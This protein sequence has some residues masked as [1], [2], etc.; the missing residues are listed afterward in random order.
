MAGRAGS[1]Y[2][3]SMK[4][5]AVRALPAILAAELECKYFWWEPIGSQPRLELHD[6]DGADY[7]ELHEEMESAD[8]LGP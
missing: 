2:I 4:Q 6:A 7:E 1:C 3:F 5:S 8:S